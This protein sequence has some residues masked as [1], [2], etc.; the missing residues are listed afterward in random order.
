MLHVDG[1]AG[2][3]EGLRPGLAA[4]GAGGGHDRRGAL[5][6]LPF[7]PVVAQGGAEALAVGHGHLALGIV[8]G[9]SAAGAEV[10]EAGAVGGTAGGRG[11][12][13][14]AG[15]A[16]GF[17][18]DQL[19]IGGAL[20][21]LQVRGQGHGGGQ[22]AAGADVVGRM[23]IQGAAGRQRVVVGPAMAEGGREIL[24]EGAVAAG[25]AAPVLVV[26]GLVAGGRMGVVVR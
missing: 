6:N 11:R 9:L 22:T 2:I 13:I 19:R 16:G 20:G 3:D 4:A 18:G 17:P 1:D 8:G 24:P 15:V 10:V 5:Q 14:G 26:A 21:D 25:A 7:A 23:A 12:D